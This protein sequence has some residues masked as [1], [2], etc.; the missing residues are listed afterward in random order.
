M[1]NITIWNEYVHEKTEEKVRNIYPNGIHNAIKDFL[2]CDE[3]NITTATLDDPECGLT[4]EVVDNTDVMLW[5]GH[6]AHG[7]VPD[8]VAKRVQEAVL[9]GMGII[10]LHSAHKSKPFMNLIGSTGNLV[11]R[12][13]D[14]KELLWVISP[15]HPIAQG[16]G[17]YVEI[18][19]EETYGEPFDIPTPDEI[20]FSSWFT[21]G[22]IFR[23][24]ITYKR[25]YGKIFYFKPGHESYP[26]YYQEE[27]QTI[28]KNAVKWVAPVKRLDKLDCANVPPVI[29]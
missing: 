28:I 20:V 5:W 4:Q 1:L 19:A 29:Q 22:E 24:G 27:I 10:F 16:L 6:L 7:N 3:Y 2:Q 18:P 26:I 13:S 23:S 14:D 15:T 12:E 21:G 11:W 8:E 9:K 17:R 25:G